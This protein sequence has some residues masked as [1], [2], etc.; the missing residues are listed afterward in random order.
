MVDGLVIE[1]VQDEIRKELGVKESD[2]GTIPNH[3][4]ALKFEYLEKETKVTDITW[5]YGKRNAPLTVML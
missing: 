3:S 1:C 2:E 5:Y 4:I